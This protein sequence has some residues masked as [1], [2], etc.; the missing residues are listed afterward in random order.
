MNDRKLYEQILGITAPW[1]VEQVELKLESGQV[2]IRVEGSSAV[3]VCPECGEV[4][5]WDVWLPS[6]GQ[7]GEYRQ[8]GT[9]CGDCDADLE[10]LALITDRVDV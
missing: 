7:V 2:L 4:F 6:S 9:F 1:Q 10:G 5:H 8:V 3:L